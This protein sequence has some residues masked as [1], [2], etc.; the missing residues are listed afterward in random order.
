MRPT[1]MS[2]WGTVTEAARV[3][4]VDDN[5]RT[6]GALVAYLSVLDG[7]AI[8][9]EA[10]NGIQAIDLLPRVTPDIVLMDASMPLMG[11]IEATRIVK[12]RWPHVRVVILTIYPHLQE[13]A[14]S[15]GADAVLVKGC[16]L[17]EMAASLKPLPT[18]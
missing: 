13:E 6:R 3:M 4:V 8:V 1:L 15:A 18:D 16:P 14:R 9:G 11:G 5:P 10:F 7:V 2:R 17:E 12:Q